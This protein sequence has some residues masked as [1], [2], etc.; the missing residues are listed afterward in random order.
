MRKKWHLN[1]KT[2]VLTGASGGIGS[3]IA[4]EL[5]LAGAKLILVGRDLEK[6]ESLNQL[7]GGYHFCLK[8]DLEQ[9]VGRE[10]LVACCQ[11]IESGIDMLINCVGINQF[12]LLENSSSESVHKMMSVNVCS[13][14]LVCQAL[15]P[16]LHQQKKTSIINIGS[17]FGSIGY[18]GFSIYCASKFALHGFTESLRRELA[19]T[20]I[21][22]G[23]FAPR[24]T[25]TALNNE[26]I[27]NMN[28]A[29][30]TDMDS[31]RHVAKE[32][33]VFLRKRKRRHYFVGWPEKLF[34]KVNSLFPG[35]VDGSIVKQLP[36]IKRFL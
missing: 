22:V 8:T 16:L 18:P 17:A 36:Q 27:T 34:V 2:I 1:R 3:E 20:D 28:I 35:I 11:Q 29:L 26:S 21:E 13:T 10:S 19:D 6:L 25:K 14:I 5:F 23:Y 9:E 33:M 15:L 30:G 24:A 12:S 7:I 32:L 31:P 4:K